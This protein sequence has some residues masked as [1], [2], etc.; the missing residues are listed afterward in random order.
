[1]NT[2]FFSVLLF[3]LFS[4]NTLFA[5]NYWTQFENSLDI[6]DTIAQRNILECWKKSG[7]RSPEYYIA[8]FNYYI[9]AAKEETLILD[10]E[11]PAEK[12]YIELRQ[13]DT[14]KENT[15][16]YLYSD[17]HY[18]IPLIKNSITYIDEGIRKY[19]SRLDLRLGKIYIL[20]EIK[21]YD[22]M[23][24]EITTTIKY[25]KQI[26]HQ[27]SGE[28]G[29][30]I[31]ENK[32]ELL[33][34]IQDYIQNLFYNNE[35]S[36]IEKIARF[37]LDI[38]PDDTVNLSNLAI[39]YI[40]NSKYDEAIKTLLKAYNL[41]PEDHIILQNLAYSYQQKG[42]KNNAIKYY[43]LASIYGTEEIKIFAEEAIRMLNAK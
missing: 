27:W 6:K 33:N 35:Y 31:I 16:E 41:S 43:K 40:A 7:N 13:T 5:N 17:I 25:S 12:E 1:M 32:E 30:Q 11:L 8:W 4:L 14:L 15:S 29:S 3:S 18:K 23:S 36:Y 28:A 10:T 2:H 20:Q 39:T 21:E 22:K 26:N 19:P 38:Y 24:D 42:D 37:I 34:I 9:S